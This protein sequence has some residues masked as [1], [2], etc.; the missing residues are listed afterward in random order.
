MENN[1]SDFMYMINGIEI[2]NRSI[3][4]GLDLRGPNDDP[5]KRIRY[6]PK[7]NKLILYTIIDNCNVSYICHPTH[8]KFMFNKFIE[9]TP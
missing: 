9:R 8:F 3:E 7:Y 5:I 4:S 2:L 6:I 1:I